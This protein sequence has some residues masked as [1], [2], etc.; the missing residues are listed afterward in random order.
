[1]CGALLTTGLPIAQAQTNPKIYDYFKNLRRGDSLQTAE[2]NNWIIDKTDQLD[3]IS[4]SMALEAKSY[5]V[6]AGIVYAESQIK[7]ILEDS[8][9]YLDDIYDLSPYLM[10]YKSYLVMPAIVTEIDG[11]KTYL[12]NT[13][14]AF[15]YADKTYYIQSYPYFIDSPPSWRDYV[16]FNGKSPTIRSQKLLPETSDEIEVWEEEFHSGWDDGIQIAIQNAK[17]QLTRGLYDVQGVITYVMLR[18]SGLISAPIYHESSLPV[19]GTKDKLE[20]FGGSI[21]IQVEPR[22]IHDPTN[23]RAI[24]QLP[25][26]DNL[27]PRSVYDLINRIK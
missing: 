5:G 20:L 17:Y 23:W 19:S 21:S 13:K 25:P 16:R 11:R 22:M 4:R 24:P 27:L 9:K 15:T 26:L 2:S 12:D 6:E 8:S 10:T 18:D 7:K 1:M 3:I 14:T